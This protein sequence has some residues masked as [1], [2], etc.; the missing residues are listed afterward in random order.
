[1]DKIIQVPF[2]LVKMKTIDQ[3]P[4]TNSFYLQMHRNKTTTAR[5]Y[6][7]KSEKPFTNLS[8]H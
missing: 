4:S 7:Q 3:I 6:H 2:F 8:L 5:A 1:M